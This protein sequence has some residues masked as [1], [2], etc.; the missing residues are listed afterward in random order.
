VYGACG[1]GVQPPYGS[2]L[3]LW[4]WTR[5]N[6]NDIDGANVFRTGRGIGSLSGPELINLVYHTLVRNMSQPERAKLDLD[7]AP[8][9]MR[10]KTIDQQN[11]EA[12]KLLTGGKVMP[13]PQPLPHRRRKT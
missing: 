10:E 11:A 4:Q 6:W 12:M 1:V 3:A 9:S 8:A 5:G 2:V 7:L 13:M